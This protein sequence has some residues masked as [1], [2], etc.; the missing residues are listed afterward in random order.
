MAKKKAKKNKSKFRALFELDTPPMTGGILLL[1]AFIMQLSL[2]SFA[3]G[4][5]LLDTPWAGC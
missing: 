5:G 2:I 1:S 4:Q 3:S